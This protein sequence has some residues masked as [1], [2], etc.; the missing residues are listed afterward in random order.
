MKKTAVVILN[1]NGC[2]F[3]Q[4]FLPSVIQYSGEAE[5]I[6]ADNASTDNSVD[7]LSTSY[8]ALRVIQNTENGGFAQ[9]YNDALNRIK[10]EFDYYVLLNSDVEVTANWLTPMLELIEQDPTIAG[11]QPKI[12]SFHAREKFEYAGASGG[13]VDHH[14]YPFC[15]GRIFSNLEI[16]HGQYNYPMEVF[17]TSGAAMLVRADV[18]HQLDGL[19]TD[20]FAH[21]EEI[22]F[23]FRAKLRGYSMMIVP[24]STVFHVGGGTLSYANPKKTFLNFRNSLFMIH[25]N[26]PGR[27][28]GKI[29]ARLLLDGIAGAMFL[30]KGQPRHTWAVL[31][32]HIA[33]YQSISRLNTKRRQIQLDTLSFRS[34]GMFNGSIIYNFYIKG[35]KTFEA[36]NKR[37]MRHK[38]D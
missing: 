36:L 27:V 13:F 9:G 29:I 7:F 16:D 34:I 6:V 4:Q 1:W 17:W 10:G 35:N 14:Y 28:S 3:L 15:R 23:C 38:K 19:D 22:D 5:V 12:M 8:P 26:H 18:Y 37:L 11:I 25:K 21:M 30:M 20:F 33:Y 31:R 32:A 24:S 2:S